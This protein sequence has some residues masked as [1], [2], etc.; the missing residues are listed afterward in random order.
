[1]TMQKLCN[2]AYKKM[3]ALTCVPRS[4]GKCILVISVVFLCLFLYRSQTIATFTFGKRT[5]FIS[6]VICLEIV[7]QKGSQDGGSCTHF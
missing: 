3:S 4:C 6:L 1:M 7:K 5:A 2:V